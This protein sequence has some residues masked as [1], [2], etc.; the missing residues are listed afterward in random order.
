M[1]QI[2]VIVV[3]AS[4]RMGRMLVRAVAESRHG[5]L[6]G[7]TERPGSEF[8]GRDAGEL[9]GVE[10]LAVRIVDDINACADADVLIDFTA[11]AATLKH[12]AFA[13]G[14]GMGMVIGTTGFDAAQMQQ[15]RDTLADSPV[16]MAANY[17]VGVNLA[18][19]LIE[20]AAQVLGDDY[21]AEIFEAHH[22]HKVDAPSGTALAM[23]KALAAGRG[24][25]L[26]D[27]AVLSR[28]GITG[29]RKAGSIG[30]S[31]VRGGNIVGEH[32]AMFIA[33]E[34]RIEIH[35]NASDR[36]VFARGAV[37]AASWLS[38]QSTGW[39]DMQDVLGLKA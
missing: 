31:V 22:K 17:S 25:A 37:R 18:L 5:L 39:Y 26:D 29:V 20:R 4:G 21:D 32:Q 35:H 2:R 24:V 10:T 7:A 19:S 1:K 14:R 12:A 6:A 28:E 27:V 38:E 23:G 16:I 36:M 9:A 30:F 34:E 15:L 33:D 13:A 11:P 3:G 8:V